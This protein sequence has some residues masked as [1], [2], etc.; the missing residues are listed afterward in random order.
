LSLHNSTET[1]AICNAVA[2]LG[3]D[4]VWL[5]EGNLTSRVVDGEV[6]PEPDVDVL[7]NRLLVTKADRPLDDLGVA[8]AF[9][10]VRPMLNPPSAVVGALHKYA[11]ATRLADAGVPVPDAFLGLSHDTLAAGRDHVG[12]NA[13]HKTAIGT[14]GAGMARVD[15]DEPLGP[16]V[17]DRRTFLQRHVGAEGRPFDVRAYVVD[18]TVL[19]AM[20]RYAP[21]DEWRTNVAL[22]GSV[23]DVSG[24]LPDAARDIARRATAAFDLDYAGVDLV[25]DRSEDGPDWRV[26]EV[27]TTAGFK[28]FFEATGTSPAPAIARLA[29]ERAGGS[30]DAAVVDRLA[31]HLADRVPACKPAAA[32]DGGRAERVSLTETVGVGGTDGVATATAKADTGAKRT[33]VDI[34]LAGEVGAGPVEGTTRVRQA[35]GSARRPVVDV[36][37]GIGGDWETVRASLADRSGMNYPVLLGRDVLA[38]RQVVVDDGPGDTAEE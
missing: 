22:G 5:R 3:H 10:G 17:A 27:N 24:A 33:C 32:T 9:E 4:P 6:R 13:V 16:R 14:N 2:D 31:G 38:G 8:G 7:V 1:K 25:P 36:E 34:D 12:E 29:V 23:E 35:S 15:D 21:D 28:G 20:R 11:A 37:V 19:G 18:G 30:V 26:L